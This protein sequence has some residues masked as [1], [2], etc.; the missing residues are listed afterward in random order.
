MASKLFVRDGATLCFLKPKQNQEPRFEIK[1]P[2]IS[3]PTNINNL[4]RLRSLVSAGEANY[5]IQYSRISSSETSNFTA[6]QSQS[7]KG[8][9][10]L[11]HRDFYGDR[12]KKGKI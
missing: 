2:D 6:K 12:V 11:S 10:P 1:K 4:P 8:K 9:I 7:P 3:S 5:R